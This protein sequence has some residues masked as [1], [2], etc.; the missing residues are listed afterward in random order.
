MLTGEASQKG[1]KKVQQLKYQSNENN[2]QHY[3]F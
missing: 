1:K 2:N 3:N